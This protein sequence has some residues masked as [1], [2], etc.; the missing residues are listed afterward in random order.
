MED[1]SCENTYINGVKTNNPKLNIILCQSKRKIG[2]MRKKL[3]K[4]GYYNYWNEEYLDE[5]LGND[6]K[7]I[8]KIKNPCPYDAKESLIEES[9][10]YKDP[11]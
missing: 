11:E 5:V 10:S 8:Q 2:Q 4:T 6:K 1:L 9:L 7:L 3:A